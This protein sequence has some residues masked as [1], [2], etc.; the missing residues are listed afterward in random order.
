[1]TTAQI[2]CDRAMVSISLYRIFTNDIKLLFYAA[3]SS[4]TIFAAENFDSQLVSDCEIMSNTR[5]LFV[6][7]VRDFFLW[8][9]NGG[10]VN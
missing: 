3:I 7:P 2:I 5:L 8:V 6:K 4:K 1:M 9:P 10:K